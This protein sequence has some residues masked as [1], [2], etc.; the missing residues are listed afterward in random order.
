MAWNGSNGNQGAKAASPSKAG[1][2]RPL[3]MRGI[4]AGGVCSVVAFCAVYF[5]MFRQS[6]NIAPPLHEKK[7]VVAI[8]EVGPSRPASIDE[9]EKVTPPSRR[10]GGSRKEVTQ[11]ENEKITDVQV[12]EDA[13]VP[14]SKPKHVEGDYAADQ[15]L[16]MTAAL[17]LGRSVP[18]IPGGPSMT[19]DFKE[20]LKHEIV[21]DE[22]DSEEVKA[23]KALIIAFREELKD[24]VKDGARV[25]DVI[26][27]HEN[28]TR[29]NNKIREDIIKEVKELREKGEEEEA[30][31]Y[32]N[33]MNAAIQQMGID[34]IEIPLTDAEAEELEEMEEKQKGTTK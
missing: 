32:L 16:G 3:S 4:V 28:L 25:E 7:T 6:K 34:I 10:G 31:R 29:D 14:E 18:P 26:R 1:K 5:T 15:I 33:T 30:S 20:S 12:E 23:T 22:N 27:D 19:R 17:T 9:P 21:I 13:N 8:K 24:L 11:A 2:A